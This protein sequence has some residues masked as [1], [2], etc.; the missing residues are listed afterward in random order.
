MGGDTLETDRR[1]IADF[2]NEYVKNNG[3]DTILKNKDLKNLLSD[4]DVSPQS[5]F[6]LNSD[7]CYNR[8]N[9]GII[10]T[11]REEIHLFEHVKRG[12]YRLLGENYPY[13]GDIKHKKAKEKEEYVAGMWQDGVI[14]EWNPR[15]G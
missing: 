7:L 6:Y 10:D 13:T 2:I 12:Y 14:V 1:K 3:N 15:K 8:V 9:D 11:F 5:V 4:N